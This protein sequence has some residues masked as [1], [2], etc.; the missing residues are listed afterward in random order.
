MISS[1]HKMTARF[2][3]S[4]AILLKTCHFHLLKELNAVIL[5]CFIGKV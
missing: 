1:E 2:S 4:C 3:V 5:F